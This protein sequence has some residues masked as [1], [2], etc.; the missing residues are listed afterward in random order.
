MGGPQ[1]FQQR[2][3]AGDDERQPGRLAGGDRHLDALL[4][5][6]APRH[7]HVLAGG[8]RRAL[9]ERAD[10]AGHDARRRDRRPELGEPRGGERAGHHEDVGLR[11]QPP[12]PERERGAVDGGLGPGP[13]AVQPHAGRGVAPVAARA[14]LA[15]RAE[16]RPH[17]ADE[18]VVVQVQD[19]PRP[20]LA[21][22]R[23]RAPA[24]RRVDVVGVDHARPGQPDR[25]ADVLGSDAAA[26]Q[27]HRGARA[28]ERRRVAIEQLRV[29]AEVL[30][31]EPAAGPRRRAPPRRWCGSGCAG[32]GSRGRTG[33]QLPGRGRVGTR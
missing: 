17:R 31:H 21:G 7:E 11:G 4:D 22:G 14:V 26:Q 16:A 30:A 3:V 1:R 6:H 13:A 9:G 5:R 18:P 24:E 29:L 12:L 23:E 28:A 20:G 32:R 27:R 25:P 2:A 33:S 19:D 15:A 10:H 8:R